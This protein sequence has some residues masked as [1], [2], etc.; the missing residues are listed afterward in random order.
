MKK[1]VLI[2]DNPEIRETTQE[3]LELA[4]YEVEV[5]EN[6]KVGVELVKKAKPDIVICDIMMPVLDGYGV[7]RILSKNPGTSTIPFIFLTAKA[8]KTD[9]RKGMNLGADDYITKP[10]DESE[11]L[12]VIESRI[13]RA[14]RFK[15][16]EDKPNDGQGIGDSDN[17]LEELSDLMHDRKIKSYS[18]KEV[19]YREDDYANYL[20]HIK[21]GKVKCLKSDSY[22]KDMV[23]DIHGEGEFIG[24]MALLEEGDYHETA[25]AMEETEVSVIPKEDF[26]KLI[27]SNRE[28]A[29]NFIKLL[30]GNVKDRE[31]RMLHLAYSPLKERVAHALLQ[32][33]QKENSVTIKLSRED[34]ACLIGTAKE[35]LVRTLSDFKKEDLISTD[36][37]DITI[38]NEA[39]L[40]SYTAY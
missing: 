8:D 31:E 29:T 32:L 9:L 11:L 10:F 35:S 21:K 5:A 25:V 30:A 15:K 13:V 34:L 14:E 39:G 28:V 22:G 37:Q 26:I 4:D 36:G 19:I 40:E 12:E 24:Y 20:Y 1:I 2:E 7:L 17:G 3:I 16:F 23:S 18:K 38:L 6:G 27:K 33:K